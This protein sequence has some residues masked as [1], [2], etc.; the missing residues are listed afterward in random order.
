MWVARVEVQGIV[1]VGR[2]QRESR[3]AK[4]S[5]FL[6]TAGDW[7]FLWEVP[8]FLKANIQF[9]FLY[10]VYRPSKNAIVQTSSL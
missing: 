9:R 4:A 5:Y 7:E 1:T 6:S 8:Q 3:V 2:G 10:T